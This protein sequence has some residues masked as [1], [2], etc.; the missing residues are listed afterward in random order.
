MTDEARLDAE[1]L[2]LLGF[3][4]SV[5]GFP[6]DFLLMG[7]VMDDAEIGEHFSGV[8]GFYRYPNPATTHH[9]SL[10]PN[11]STTDVLD[12]LKSWSPEQRKSLHDRIAHLV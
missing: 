1:V 7:A 3:N 10:G 9:F 12:L 6:V 4:L 11:V 8:P 5:I 2:K